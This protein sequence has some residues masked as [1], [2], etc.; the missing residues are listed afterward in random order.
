MREAD[1]IPPLFDA[2]LFESACLSF[3]LISGRAQVSMRK[4]AVPFLLATPF[5][6]LETEGALL[7]GRNECV[8]DG[9]GFGREDGDCCVWGRLLW[10]SQRQ[11]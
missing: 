6:L 1:P 3:K 7:L 2:F 4:E 10:D 8:R 11:M 5:I 9:R